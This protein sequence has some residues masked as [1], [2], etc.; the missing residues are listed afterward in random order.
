MSTNEVLKLALEA[1][2]WTEAWRPQGLR[3]EAINALQEALA[4]ERSSDEQ[5]AQRKPLTDEQIMDSFIITPG[6]RQ[7]VQAFKAGAR[8]AEA[9]HGIKENI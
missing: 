3:E 4:Q 7:L 5:P 6:M 8:F 2:C 1:L 9:A